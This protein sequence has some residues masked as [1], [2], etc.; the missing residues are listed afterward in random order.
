[1][2]RTKSPV[3]NVPVTVP[4]LAANPVESFEGYRSYLFAI[5]YRML[6]SAMDA[7]DMVQET[8]IRYQQAAATESIISL[9]AYLTTIL[10]RLCIGQLHLAHRTREE[11]LGTWLPEPI[12]TAANPEN[13]EERVDTYEEVS[14]A[15]LI[16]LEQLHPVERAVFLLREVFEYDYPEIAEFLGKSEEACRKWLSR[17]KKHLA[18][19]EV[20]FTASPEMHQQMLTGFL[21]VVKAGELG[22]MMDLLA[23]DV[24]F[25]AD[26]GGNAKG[27][28]TRSLIGRDNVAK[29]VIQSDR[30]LPQGNHVGLGEVNGQPAL[31]VRFNGQALVVLTI[32][33]TGR[34]VQTIRVIANPAK[35]AYV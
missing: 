11:Y 13:T 27:A 12:T 18:G 6:G 5:G 7:E 19:H 35:L 34:H 20:R 17:A 33:L 16:L 23:E 24:T 15:F 10:T 30:F 4:A 22:A 9:K 32:E 1:V 3:D 31:I 2:S 29:F 26:G 28:A 8:Y 21:D 25:W 14:L